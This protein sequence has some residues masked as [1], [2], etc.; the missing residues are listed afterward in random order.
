MSVT[1]V[2]P[3]RPK[4]FVAT[5][6]I[7]PPG[8]FLNRQR[9]KIFPGKTCWHLLLS[10]CQFSLFKGEKSAKIWE[11]V[12][13]TNFRAT[14]K[15]SRKGSWSF[16]E[17]RFQSSMVNFLLILQSF[18]TRTWDDQRSS[19]LILKLTCFRTICFSDSYSSIRL[20]V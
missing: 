2:K 12:K 20:T 17:Y 13:A 6:I 15:R 14:V 10:K 5:Y 3:I 7:L 4:F 16:A 11:R 19:M 18:Q 1:T 9:C 8:R